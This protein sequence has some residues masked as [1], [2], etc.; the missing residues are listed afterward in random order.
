MKRIVFASFIAFGATVAAAQAPAP[1][2]GTADA[3]PP[4]SCGNI[5]EYP[6]RLGSDMQ[7]RS[8]D[9]AYK[10]YDKCIRAYIDDRVATIKA[11]EAMVNK[12]VD[13]TNE[14]VLKMKADSGEDVSKKVE[15]KESAPAAPIQQPSKKG[16]Y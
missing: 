6:G 4:H 8:F 2:T 16:G 3:V 14:L 5:P 9:R 15:S 1:G 11:N 10:A 7:K 13:H 12:V